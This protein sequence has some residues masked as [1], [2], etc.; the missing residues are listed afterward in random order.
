MT[1]VFRRIATA[2]LS[3]ALLLAAGVLPAHSSAGEIGHDVSQPQCN[4]ATLPAG[5]FGIVGV[6]NKL[7]YSVNPC[8]AVQSQWALATGSPAVYVNTANPGHTSAHWPTARVTPV[9]CVDVTSDTDA[10]CAYD[11]GWLAARDALGSA[12]AAGMAFDPLTVTW[13]IDVEG[14]RTPG[15]PG[16]SWVGSGRSNAADLQGFIDALRVAGVRDV[17]VYSTA[18]QWNDITG[19]YTRATSNAYRAAWSFRV[20]YPIEDSPVWFAGVGDVTSAQTLCASASFTGGERLLAQ[21]RD[22]SYDGDLRCAVADTTRP[23]VSVLQPT[24]RTTNKPYIGFSWRAAD[25]G[26]S[27]IASYDVRYKRAAAHKGYGAWAG[28]AAWQRTSAR[29]V[30][31][32]GVRIG[33]G[34][35]FTVRSRDAAGNVSGWSTARCV[36]RTS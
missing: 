21:Y 8:L 12:Q 3:T 23:T 34:Y 15:A 4:D 30:S 35:C 28:P 22:G 16:N 13:W 7:P 9:P 32:T 5:A 11:Y 14:S 31:V 6:T 20:R 19:G 26:G 24:G 1:G 18:H 27:G 25:A 2:A 29:N 36:R 10:G 17:G 33:V